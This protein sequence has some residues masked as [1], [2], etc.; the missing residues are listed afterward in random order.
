VS[1]AMKK[2]E[3]KSL[4][5]HEAVRKMKEELNTSNFNS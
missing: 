4:S 2:L 1:K 5:I 3:K